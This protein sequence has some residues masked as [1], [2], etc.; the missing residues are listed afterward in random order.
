MNKQELIE[1]YRD[2][3]IQDGWWES[4]YE[5][6]TERMV[7]M[8]I[9]VESVYFSGFHSQ[10]SGASF[11][12]YVDD[13]TK[14]FLAMG[15]SNAALPL[16]FE[17]TGTR[18]SIYQQSTHYYHE[19]TMR[20]GYEYLPDFPGDT[21]FDEEQFRE[22][23]EH[24]GELRTEVLLT[25]LR[26]YSTNQIEEEILEFLRGHARDLYRDLEREYEHLTSDEAVWE[27]IEINDLHTEYLQQTQEAA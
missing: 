27:V 21:Y 13:W 6:F 10:G 3:N 7:P 5:W 8:G 15:H 12:G 24:L 9:T 2:I 11:E 23:F 22:I 18:V 4:V 1:K 17:E 25:V 16:Y 20:L 19:N 26:R 14:L